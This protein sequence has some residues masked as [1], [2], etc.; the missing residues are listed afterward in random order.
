M[1]RCI[2]NGSQHF[3]ARVQFSVCVLM[4]NIVLG[5]TAHNTE[6]RINAGFPAKYRGR[7]SL[8]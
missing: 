7:V 6:I 2:E 4:Q 3:T 5:A 1:E 8:A